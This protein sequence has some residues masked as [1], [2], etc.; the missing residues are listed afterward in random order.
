M[1][2]PQ[3]LGSGRKRTE[4]RETQGCNQVWTRPLSGHKILRVL[5]SCVLAKGRVLRFLVGSERKS[6][7]WVLSAPSSLMWPSR[8]HLGKWPSCSGPQWAVARPIWWLPNPWSLIKAWAWAAGKASWGGW[9]GTS[10]AAPR[11]GG[12][13][14]QRQQGLGTGMQARGAEF[15]GRGWGPGV[16]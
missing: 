13:H 8:G 11:T 7:F 14:R 15:R 12:R 6:A 3:I 4:S 10:S 2:L 9:L 5:L 1:Q 16:R